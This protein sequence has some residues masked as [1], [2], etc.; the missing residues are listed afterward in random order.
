MDGSITALSIAP[1]TY[2][3]D[4]TASMM[5]IVNLDSVWVTANVAEDEVRSSVSSVLQPNADGRR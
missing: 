1:G 2:V 5:T 4:V 3:N